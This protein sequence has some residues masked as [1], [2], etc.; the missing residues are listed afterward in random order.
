MKRL[1]VD[2]DQTIAG[3]K[4]SSYLDCAPDNELIDRLKEYRADGFEIVIHTARNMNTYN[5]SLGKIVANTVPVI[6]DWLARNGVPYDEVLVGKPWCGTEGFY[7][8]DRSVRPDEF[9]SMT[10]DEIHHLLNRQ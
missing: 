8:D 5:G 6:I 3:P 2:L 1:I 7:I 4:T 10:K 9:K